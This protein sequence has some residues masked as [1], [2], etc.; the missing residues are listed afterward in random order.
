MP[1]KFGLERRDYH[2]I[3]S[4]IIC[5]TVRKNSVGGANPFGFP[6]FWASIK[7]GQGGREAVSRLA[8]KFFCLTV[9][10][11]FVREPFIVSLISGMEKFFCFR[12]YVTIFNL[13]SIFLSHSA[14]K[15]RR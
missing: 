2:D 1:Q 4:K 13:L 8:P 3:L 10:K 11:K 6:S 7:F 14:E 12:G 9:P 15:L 5:P